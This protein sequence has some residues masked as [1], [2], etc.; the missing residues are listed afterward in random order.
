MGRCTKLKLLLSPQKTVQPQMNH[1]EFSL[2]FF[3]GLV[4][5]FT[6]CHLLRDMLFSR[7]LPYLNTFS[8]KNACGKI[9]KQCKRLKN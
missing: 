1:V 6:V 3:F 7:T 8:Y 5:N 2:L 4:Y 9:L